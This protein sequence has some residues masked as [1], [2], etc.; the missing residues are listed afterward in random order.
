[1]L[2]ILG[3]VVFFSLWDFA[4]IVIKSLETRENLFFDAP[5]FNLRT[6]CFFSF[7]H[8][9]AARKF[10]PVYYHPRDV[11]LMNSARVDKTPNTEKHIT[12]GSNLK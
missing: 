11:D 5:W 12:G 4:Q 6:G 7:S 1:M 3:Y 9:D 8:Y 10:T 2:R